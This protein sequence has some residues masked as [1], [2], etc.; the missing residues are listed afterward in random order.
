MSGGNKITIISGH[1]IML[2]KQDYALYTVVSTE[3]ASRAHDFIIYFVSPH[4]EAHVQG[5]KFA[6]SEIYCYCFL[7]VTRCDAGA[8]ACNGCAH[9]N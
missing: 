6:S 4:F 8:R 2:N 1:S 5:D 9:A 3:H 7:T